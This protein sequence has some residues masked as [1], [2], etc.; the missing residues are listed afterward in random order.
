L[1]LNPKKT[2]IELLRTLDDARTAW[3]AGSKGDGVVLMPAVY[4]EGSYAELELRLAEMREGAQRREWWHVSHR[5]R[6]GN[7]CRREVPARRTRLGPEPLLGRNCELL[8]I[9]EV[10]GRSM[11]VNLYEWSTAVDDGMVGR[12]LT[13]L[14]SIMHGGDPW[15]M[16][17][18][19]VYLYRAL[20]MPPPEERPPE[21]RAKVTLAT[22]S[23][24]LSGVGKEDPAQ[25]TNTSASP[26]SSAH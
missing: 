5:Y 21:R 4:Q 3:E 11:V 20:G 26:V 12:G 1:S 16:H 15:R 24:A 8:G 18:P 23:T 14:L 17:L 19:L 25:W 13:H 22:G 6:W 2:L 9:V 10:N 7:E